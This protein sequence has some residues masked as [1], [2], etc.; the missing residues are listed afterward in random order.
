MCCERLS[1]R[2]QP[3]FTL[4]FLRFRFAAF[5]PVVRLLNA[6]YASSKVHTAPLQASQLRFAHTSRYQSRNH[7]LDHRRQLGD[8]LYD[9]FIAPAV[10]FAFGATW[11]QTGSFGWIFPVPVAPLR[12]LGEEA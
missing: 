5:S 8:V 1:Q 11:S 10:F 6:D 12:R 9:L 2:S 7:E 4:R 3:Q